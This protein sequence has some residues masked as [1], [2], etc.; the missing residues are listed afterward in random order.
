MIT[1]TYRVAWARHGVRSIVFLQHLFLPSFH[2][3]LLSFRTQPFSRFSRQSQINVARALIRF[4]NNN[5]MFL[6]STTSE[7]KKQNGR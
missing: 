4:L 2:H 3:F 5:H 1:N 6:I 7:G